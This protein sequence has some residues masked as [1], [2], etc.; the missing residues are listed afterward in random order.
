MT[1]AAANSKKSCC[2]P[3]RRFDWLLWGSGSIVAIAYAWHLLAGTSHSG[4]GHFSAGA[5]ELINTMWWG[6]LLGI[7]FVGLLDRV[8]REILITALAG[9]RRSTGIFRA[10]AA[11][12]LFDMC[13]HGILM[14]GMKLY[15][16]G[17]TIGQTTAF[18]LAS[19]WN[20][21]SLT[22][23]LVALIGW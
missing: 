6:L 21:L 5:F 19:P 17:A 8:P 16:R 11:G 23:I 1:E 10:T 15:E 12:V 7:V 4:I 3:K 18:L 22:I 14:V 20:S 2:S 9:E 13:S